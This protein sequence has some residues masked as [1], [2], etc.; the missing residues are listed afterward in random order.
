[1]LN[2]DDVGFEHRFPKSD[3][4]RREP[5]ERHHGRPGSFRPEARKR[6]RLVA[7]HET[8][9]SKHFRRGDNPL[10]AA[11][12]NSNLKH[13]DLL[14]VNEK[15]SSRPPWDRGKESGPVLMENLCKLY[16]VSR[17]FALV[18]LTFSK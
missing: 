2:Q 10:A 6:L 14:R 18:S 5:G 15:P 7:F 8:R 9:E 11:T 3:F 13:C 16:Q 4:L 17:K 12:V 1:M